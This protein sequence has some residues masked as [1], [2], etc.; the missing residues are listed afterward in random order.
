[1]WLACDI[2]LWDVL[3]FASMYCCGVT[4]VRPSLTETSFSIHFDGLQSALRT[5]VVGKDATV[6]VRFSAGRTAGFG[7]RQIY[8]G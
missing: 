7:W 4:G 2:D 1:M 6:V 3:L 5:A 8:R